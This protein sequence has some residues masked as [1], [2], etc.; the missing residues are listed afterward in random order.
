MFKVILAITFIVLAVIWSFLLIIL[1]P[2]DG[3]R[4]DVIGERIGQ[5]CQNGTSGYP[6]I[7]IGILSD[8]DL[9][10]Q[11]GVFRKENS[12]YLQNYKII[13]QNIDNLDINTSRITSLNNCFPKWSQYTNIPIYR[14]LGLYNTSLVTFFITSAI[15]VPIIMIVLCAG[16]TIVMFYLRCKTQ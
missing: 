10:L 2:Y 3:I 1:L 15:V 6:D 7:F 8:G 16:S 9:C 5:E 13:V 11:R 14:C 4:R 12:Y